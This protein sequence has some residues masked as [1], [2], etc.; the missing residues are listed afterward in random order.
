MTVRER[1]GREIGESMDTVTPAG[2]G[3]QGPAPTIPIVNK[4]ISCRDAA[5]RVSSSATTQVVR[6][7]K[8]VFDVVIDVIAGRV[9]H[10]SCPS[11]AWPNEHSLPAVQRV[12]KYQPRDA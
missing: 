2:W 10:Q 7:E 9:D 3:I 1:R 6:I 12:I 5:C 4:Q 8:P 11:I